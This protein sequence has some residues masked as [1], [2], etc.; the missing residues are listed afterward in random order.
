[1]IRRFLSSFAFFAIIVFLGIGLVFY[2]TLNSFFH[3]DD[4][5]LLYFVHHGGPLGVRKFTPEDYFRPLTSIS[6][7]VE[8]Q[9][10]GLNVL[11]FRAIHL[12]L[13]GVV[14]LL[15]ARFGKQLGLSQKA[16]RIGAVLFAV[17]P[18][19]IEAVVWLGARSD[20]LATLLSLVCLCLIK[21]TVHRPSS[22]RLALVFLLCGL[23]MLGK[24]AAALL[25]LGIIALAWY[26]G[27]SP[28]LLRTFLWALALLPLYFLARYA[29]VGSFLGRPGGSSTFSPVGLF[30][31]ICRGLPVALSPL[32]PTKLGAMI[33]MAASTVLVG[34]GL[35]RSPISQRRA[36]RFLLAL[37]FGLGLPTLMATFVL[38]VDGTDTR[39]IYFPSVFSCLLLGIILEHCRIGTGLT[40]VVILGGAIQSHLVTRSWQQAGEWVRLGLQDIVALGQSSRLI[41][42]ATPDR[43]F[44]AYIFRRGL[45]AGMALLHQ[46]SVGELILTDYVVFNDE[47]DRVSVVPDGDGCLVTLH[48][49]TPPKA[50]PFVWNVK[51]GIGRTSLVTLTAP[52]Y[53]VSLPPPLPGEHIVYFSEGRFHPWK[54]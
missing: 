52:S 38:P 42:L 30:I 50:R 48:F 35:I 47:R 21:D 17:L 49:A 1:M 11:G 36:L 27:A 25:P 7:Y 41:V 51:K 9:L 46:H 13:H 12:F 19:H 3:S 8:H 37:F 43:R 44:P 2:P 31:A 22:S 18:G 5:D 33:V 28:K 53:H 24:E 54:R 32:A 15:V 40:T 14:T 4:L 34:W 45:G 10:W 29:Y 16:S 39:N 20:L 26:C 6:F 23:A